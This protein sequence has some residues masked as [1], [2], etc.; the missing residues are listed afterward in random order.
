MLQTILFP[1]SRFTYHDAIIWLSRHK[2]HHKKVDE[3]EHMFRFRQVDPP[4]GGYYRTITLP[5]GVELVE[6]YHN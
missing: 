3:T 5:N 2:Y 6:H 1:K 4:K